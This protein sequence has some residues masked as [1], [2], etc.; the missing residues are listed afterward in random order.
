MGGA[1][2]SLIISRALFDFSLTFSLSNE[3]RLILSASTTSF[4]PPPK[5]L[6]TFQSKVIFWSLRVG[7]FSKAVCQNASLGIF[8]VYLGSSLLIWPPAN[9][10]ESAGHLKYT[11][12]SMTVEPIHLERGKDQLWS[13]LPGRQGGHTHLNCPW[14]KPQK[15]AK[16]YWVQDAHSSG[17]V[18]QGASV[19]SQW[20]KVALLHTSEIFLLKTVQCCNVDNKRGRGLLT[21]SDFPLFSG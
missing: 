19:R 21:E 18:L 11:Q 2:V 13:W 3:F 9:I 6:G 7:S 14:H 8:K 10:Q 17:S 4:F 5:S 20:R 1:Y 12:S 15:Q 16:S